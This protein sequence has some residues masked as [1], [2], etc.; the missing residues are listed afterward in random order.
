LNYGKHVLDMRRFVLDVGY[1]YQSFQD[2][3][4]YCVL[5]ESEMFKSKYGSEVVSMDRGSIVPRCRS[6]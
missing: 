2:T 4:L 3:D 5:V 6:T 1:F